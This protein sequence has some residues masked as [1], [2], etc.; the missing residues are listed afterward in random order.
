MLETFRSCRYHSSDLY[1]LIYKYMYQFWWL[2]YTFIL[3]FSFFFL[4]GGLF[5]FYF[6]I[7]FFAFTINQ[8]I[9][10]LIWRVDLC[11]FIQSLLFMLKNLW[12]LFIFL[13]WCLYSMHNLIRFKSFAM[14][15]IHVCFRILN[16]SL[17][18]LMENQI[19]ESIKGKM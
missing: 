9:S 5:I 7:I 1:S 8:Q 15:I 18:I 12:T 13:T 2:T 16:T 10:T 4:G 17:L 11:T 19:H 3:F 14:W 6:I